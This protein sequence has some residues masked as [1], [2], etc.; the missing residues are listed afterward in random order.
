MSL[1]FR[2]LFVFRL[3]IL[4]VH[5]VDKPASLVAGLIFLG[6]HAIA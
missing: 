2:Q 4:T 5:F 6:T 1:T 3:S